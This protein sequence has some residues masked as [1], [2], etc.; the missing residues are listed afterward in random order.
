MCAIYHFCKSIFENCL[1]TVCSPEKL[2]LYLLIAQPKSVVELP[3]IRSI[4]RLNFSVEN[5]I[6]ECR[7]SLKKS[8]LC[9]SDAETDHPAGITSAMRNKKATL[10]SGFCFSEHCR[11]CTKQCSEITKDA[12]QSTAFLLHIAED[13][14]G[15]ALSE[16]DASLR[17]SQ[18]RRYKF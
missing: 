12:V 10:S 17:S 7:V 8:F 18:S 3:R 6:R 9:A 15:K 4:C 2:F 14:K 13:S 5:R 11:A 16:A 1:K